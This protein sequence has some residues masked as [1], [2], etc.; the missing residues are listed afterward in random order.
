M[1]SRREFLTY[2]ALTGIGSLLPAT[3][4]AFPGM[5][6]KRRGMRRLQGAALSRY[7]QPV[8]LPGVMQPLG[9]MNGKPYYEIPIT[10]CA[11]QV[12]P[13][14]PA[15]PFWGYNGSFPG[16][17]IE[18]RTNVPIIVSSWGS[19][20]NSYVP[21]FCAGTEYVRCATRIVLHRRTTG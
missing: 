14:L 10:M 19:H 20:R 4:P 11:Q 13:D 2:S 6:T 18:A 5:Q 3:L 17:T 8:P 15:T 16:P 9:K 7:V 1:T 12:H 21:D